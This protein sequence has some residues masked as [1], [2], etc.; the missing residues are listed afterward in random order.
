MSLK[1]VSI[2]RFFKHPVRPV[3]IGKLALVWYAAYF[4][5]QENTNLPDAATTD[6]RLDERVPID[7]Q[8]IYPY[9][10]ACLYLPSLGIL[11]IDHLNDEQYNH[12]MLAFQKIIQESEKIFL[13]KPTRLKSR[14]QLTHPLTHL[15]QSIDGPTNCFPSLH[16][17]LVT[18]AYQIIRDARTIEIQQIRAARESCIDICRATLKTRQHSIVDV[19]GGLALSDKIYSEFFEGTPEDLLGAILLE[20][21]PNELATAQSMI[22]DSSDLLNL[23]ENLMAKFQ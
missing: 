5:A 2:L 23:F 10:F 11:L 19:I 22:H 20:L 18:L 1:V 4:G 16:V 15:L 21:Q 7:E 6:T 12:A 13:K 17:A 3:M 8:A 9:L 14:R